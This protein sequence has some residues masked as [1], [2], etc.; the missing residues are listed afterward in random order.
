MTKQ[1][2]NPGASIGDPAADPNRT[3][4]T[5]S[6]VNFDTL[7]ERQVRGF[8]MGQQLRG[9]LNGQGLTIACLGDSILAENTYGQL[10]PMTIPSWVQRVQY[11]LMKSDYGWIPLPVGAHRIAL[12]QRANHDEWTQPLIMPLDSWMVTKTE[13][14]TITFR[15][16]LPHLDSRTS[17]SIYIMERTSNGAVAFDMQIQN[18]QT[19]AVLFDG[20]VDTYVAPDTIGTYGGSTNVSSRLVKRTVT[21]S[22]AAQSLIVTIDNVV[23]LD[24][25]SGVSATGTGIIFGFASGEGV[26]VRNFA[27]GSTTLTSPSAA[28]TTRGI[29]TAERLTVAKAINPDCY[30]INWGTNDSKV[31]V[32]TLTAF[33]IAY[34]AAIE[35]LRTDNPDCLIVLVTAPAGEEDS[36]Y[37]FN[38]LYN[39]VLRQMAT[40]YDNIALLDQEEVARLVGASFYA[41]EV[42]PDNP[43]HEATAYAFLTQFGIPQTLGEARTEGP[44]P[45]YAGSFVVPEDGGAYTALTTVVS[46]TIK[47]PG[48]ARGL[49][50]RAKVGLASVSAMPIAKMVITLN[51]VTVDETIAGFDIPTGGTVSLGTLHGQSAVITDFVHGINTIALQLDDCQ[52]RGGNSISHFTYEWVR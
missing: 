2:I 52:V 14:P 27:I 19:D 49:I 12:A 6:I 5:K 35:D 9:K 48:D 23:T 1:V 29:T 43:G 13:N 16:S 40:E 28:N 50:L 51:T 45:Q 33:T 3:C 39:P 24:R 7:W 21:L 4:W 15:V 34:R 11:A 22:A 8:S 30:I 37:E 38:V 10:G 32:T 31:G 47:A 44:T 18:A 26:N 25:G 20:V 36:I 46:E 17:F 41:D 42:H